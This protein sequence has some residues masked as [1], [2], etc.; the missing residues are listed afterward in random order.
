MRDALAPL[1]H[2]EFRLLF[3]GRVVSFAR[4]A[5]APIALAFGVLELG[6][7][8]GDLGLVLTLSTSREVRALPHPVPRLANAPEAA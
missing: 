7:S 2:R 4:S 1:R 3:G 8:A 6:G 5:M